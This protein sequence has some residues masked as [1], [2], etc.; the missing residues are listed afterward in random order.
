LGGTKGDSFAIS[1]GFKQLARGL[2]TLIR[3]RGIASLAGRAVIGISWPQNN[4]AGI[5]SALREGER[6]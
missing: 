4:A 6:S 1:L 2:H 3:C 5:I